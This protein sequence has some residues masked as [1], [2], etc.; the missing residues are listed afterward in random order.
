M[1]VTEQAILR[2]VELPHE[3]CLVCWYAAY[4]SANH[5]KNVA[6]Q[7]SVREVQH[8][9]PLYDSRRR[10]KDRRVTLQLPLF[11]GYVFVRIALRDRLRV[12]QVP[13]VARLVGFNGTPTAL[14]DEEVEALRSGLMQGLH[15]VPHPFLRVGRRIRV[16]SGPMAGLEGILKRRKGVSR[17]VVSVELIQRAIS[18]EIDEAEVEPVARTCGVDSEC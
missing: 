17:L 15:A 9:L 12:L 4:T 13:G 16:K 8:F 10:W 6:T 11:P 7:L 18:V 2:K 1:K 3:Y 14:P 5:E